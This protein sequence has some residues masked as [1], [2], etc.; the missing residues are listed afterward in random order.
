GGGSEPAWYY[1]LA[2]VVL[3]ACRANFNVPVL[4]LHE[5]AG[6]ARSVLGMTDHEVVFSDD[7]KVEIDLWGVVDGLIL[8]GEA[9]TGADLAASS[10]KR[11]K[12]ARRLRRAADALSADTLV[13]ATAASAWSESSISAIEDAFSGSRCQIEVRVGVDS[14]LH[15]AGDSTQG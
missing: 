5:I 6:N 3:Q 14:H 7:D 12:K 11:T 10:A 2:E 13:L 15:D 1:A 9:K 8:L 4:A